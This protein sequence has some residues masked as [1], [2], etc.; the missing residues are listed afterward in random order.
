V[1]ASTRAT[2]RD[3]IR[4]RDAILRAANEL[5]AEVGGS[6]G[7]DV[8]A[9]RA[10]VGP[11]TLYRHFPTKTHLLDAV[12]EDRVAD[13]VSVV[14]ASDEIGDPGVAFRTLLH[15]IADVQVRDRTFRDLVAWRDRT[16]G[17][18]HPS[19]HELGRTLTSAV[20][21]AR[22]A[23]A[24]RADV[25]VGDVMLMLIALDGIS[26]SAGAQAPDAL[27]RIVDLVLDGLC[28]ART[29][30]SGA[31]LDAEGLLVAARPR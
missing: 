21:R 2:R 6:V 20:V 13:L 4:N 7:V 1:E 30:L 16:T 28:Q 19:I 14:R 18:P 24:L 22:D 5:V 8:I 29:P 3:A 23:G 26:G 10:G 17:A 15:A 12:L 25:A 27:H 31:P 9:R 11:A